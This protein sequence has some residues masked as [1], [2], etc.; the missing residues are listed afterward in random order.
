MG[1]LPPAARRGVDWA[2][3]AG[4]AGVLALG[5]VLRIVHLGSRLPE[6]VYPDE[7]P[8]LHLALVAL[9]GDLAP[10][11]IGWPPASIHIVAAAV[12]LGRAGGRALVEGS[13]ELLLFGRGL[14]VAVSL[15]AV[16]LA[17]VTGALLA[18]SPDRRRA[19]AWGAAGAMAVSYLSVRL[20]RQVHPDHL[21]VVF[22]TAAFAC[23]VAFDRSRRWPWLAGAGGLAG[24]AGA[25]KYIGILVALPA[26]V[27]VL[28]TT[29]ARAS[30]LRRLAVVGVTAP[31]GFLA[32]SPGA[33]VDFGRFREGLAFQV[34][35]QATGHLG[36]E[37][38]GNGWWFHLGRS[39]PGNWGWPLT[40][41][42]L[43]GT[44]WVM[45]R[46][47]RPQRLAASFVVPVL[48]V[49]GTFQARFP[50]YVLVL[51]PFLA[52]LAFVAVLRLGGRLG[53]SGS[54]AAAGL[55][56]LTLLPTVVDDARLLRAEAAPETRVLAALALRSLPGPLWAESYTLT[57][58]ADPP[59]RA[60]HALG[61]HP[62]VLGCDCFVVVSSYMEDRFRRRRDLYASQVGVYEAMRAR[63]R[64]VAVVRPAVPLSYRWDV[65]PGWG[66]RKV[67]LRG[68]AG[69]V[70]PT[71]TILDL[72]ATA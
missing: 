50:H 58:T 51:L 32:G 36:Y 44:A 35:R 52:A 55:L 60:V 15:L 5:G 57:G 34:R 24:L 56:A 69:P 10:S 54:L 42:A 19:T 21:Q 62:E 64:V 20:G 12:G 8:I 48:A 63:G 25:A 6:V 46:G 68:E 45:A 66:T 7:P 1:V 59:A 61:D 47:T 14:F 16:A 53:E 49:V 2:L 71:L 26:V 18:D 38:E 23:V 67:P 17:G 33:L 70:G 4:M 40:V 39:L 9:G 43:V 22:T 3:L 28:W 72:R 11:D 30:V 29:E 27:S 13:A 41:A 65:L 37:A 31:L